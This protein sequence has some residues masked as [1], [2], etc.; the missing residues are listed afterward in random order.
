MTPDALALLSDAVKDHRCCAIRYRD[1]MQVRVIEPHAIYRNPAGEI[2]VD[3]YQTGGYSSA[4]RIPPFWRP[5]RLSKINA[6]AVLRDTFMPRRTE[7]YNP[8]RSRYRKGLICAVSDRDTHFI[9]PFE[10]KVETVGP[11]LPPN[12]TRR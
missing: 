8:S 6:V 10:Q 4:N 3:C 11:F 12:Q 2:I 7:G 1:Q 5:F 9:Y